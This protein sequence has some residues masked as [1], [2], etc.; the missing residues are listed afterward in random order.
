MA[1]FSLNE[2]TINPKFNFLDTL[3]PNADE[4][5]NLPN[6]TFTDSP[7]ETATF[8]C[9][10]LS[11]VE[12]I[13]KYKNANKPSVLSINIQSL[14]SKFNNFSTFI[15]SLL[16]NN[17]APDIICIQ[18]LWQIPGSDYFILDGYHPLVY[19]LRHSSTQGGGVGIYVKK[20][21]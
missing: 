2:L 9:E 7:Y 1:N 5:D 11:E 12:T 4:D 20:R 16:V 18:E 15:N 13:N 8:L 21:A 3:N 17:C 6:F 19:K 14:Q 10:Y